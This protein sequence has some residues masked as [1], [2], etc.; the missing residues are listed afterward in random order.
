MSNWNLHSTNSLTIM[1]I[2]LGDFNA[3]AHREDIFKEK[4]GTE[5]L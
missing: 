2:L 5:G 4:T 1:E 3:R